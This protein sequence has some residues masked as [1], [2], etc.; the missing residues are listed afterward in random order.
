MQDYILI[1]KDWIFELGL[2]Y[3]VNPLIFGTIYV[4]AIPI[5]S[6]SVAWIIRNYRSHKPIMLPVISATLFFIS[7]YLYLIWAGENVPFWVYIV[8]LCILGSTGYSSFLRIRRKIRE[9]QQHP[10]EHR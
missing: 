5:F 4:G 7:S 8:I 3:D 10:K 2:R 9:H 1:L 6:A